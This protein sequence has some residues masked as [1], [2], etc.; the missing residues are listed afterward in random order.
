MNQF[1]IHLP[2]F[3]VCAVACAAALAAPGAFAVDYLTASQAQKL[4]FPGAA[5]FVDKTILLGAEQMRGVERIG[6]IDARSQSWAFSHALAS[7]GAY[8]GSV[9]IDKVVGKFELITY[10]VGI[11]AQGTIKG[12]EI[13]SY[14]ESHGGEIRLPGWRKQFS[15]KTAAEPLRIGDDIALI[16]GATLSCTHVTDG[17]RRIT[18][19]WNVLHSMGAL[20]T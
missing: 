2:A 3:N 8:Q 9:I 11:D 10:A 13:L 6:K 16:S 12:V 18:A 19:I 4:M 1:S 14:R 5:S 15:G 17:V 20:Q 7:D